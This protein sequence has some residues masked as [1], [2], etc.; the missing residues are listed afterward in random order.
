[1]VF[2][3]GR[4]PALCVF[5][6]GALCSINAAAQQRVPL[7][8]AEAEDLALQNEPGQ[9]ALLARSN[10]LKEQAVVA[11]QLPD[12][13]M[14][15]GLNNYP[16][17]AGNFSTE[18]MTHAL[19][20]LRQAFPP[21]NS[22]AIGARQFRAMAEQQTSNAQ[23]RGLDVL[24]AT[25]QAW[26]ESYYWQQAGDLVAS[27]RP[28][29][30]DLAQITRSLYAVGR[31]NQQDV[32]RAELELSRLDD[33]LL[34]TSRQLAASQAAL[35]QWIGAGATRPVARVLPNWD[36]PPVRARILTDLAQHPMLQAADAAVM[37]GN[38]GVEYAKEQQKPGWS[39]DLGYSY[40][41]GYLASGDPRSDFVSL[42]VTVDLPFFNRK[43]R[44]DRSLAAAL[45]ERSA[46]AS[47]R[48]QLHRQLRSRVDAEFSR[49]QQTDRRLLLYEQRILPQSGEQAQ[50]ALA[51]Y[52]S[53][54]GDFADVMR[55][56]ID[57][58]NT[59][60]DYL[61]LQVDRAQSHAELKTL[62]GMQK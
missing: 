9:A 55:S 40:R 35:G 38:A 42:S 59:R 1:M 45:S 16:I 25:R 39:V 53:D 23:A 47:S 43:R 17:E 7:T 57:D 52:Q 58:L 12:P 30:D 2:V 31:R 27:S 60:L 44:Q 37:A 19:V 50:A 3:H 10:A 48:E 18:A 8:L 21:G 46:V 51:A 33:R 26:L 49:W 24:G 62:G 41:E 32:L 20:G 61:R 6:I 14:R 22:R 13:A 11:G 5:A 54:T 15:I 56:H 36:E 28:F 4:L 29:F 34:E